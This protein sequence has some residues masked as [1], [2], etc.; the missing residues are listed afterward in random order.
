MNTIKIYLLFAFSLLFSV[1]KAARIYNKAN[2]H[3]EVDKV[4][5]EAVIQGASINVTDTQLK[6]GIKAMIRFYYHIEDYISGNITAS[7]LRTILIA[8]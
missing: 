4:V 2:L 3:V 1:E 5:D 8:L 6:N 7:E